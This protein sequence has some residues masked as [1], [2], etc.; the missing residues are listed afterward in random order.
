MRVLSWKLSVVIP[1]TGVPSWSWCRL[2]FIF[3]LLVSGRVK[4][5]PCFHDFF[6]LYLEMSDLFILHE[7]FYRNLLSEYCGTRKD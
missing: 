6:Y 3:E 2:T 4:E 7:I 1:W 5:P